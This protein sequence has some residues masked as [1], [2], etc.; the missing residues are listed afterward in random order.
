MFKTARAVAANTDLE[1]AQSF[2]FQQDLTF[3]GLVIAASGDDCFTK[4]RQVALELGDN[5]L[6]EGEIPDRLERAMTFLK[7]S[8][9]E[10]EESQI[11]L[12]SWQDNSKLTVLY[13]RNSGSNQAFLDRRGKLTPLTT[14][15]SQLIS[16]YIQPGDKILLINS[17]LSDQ[18]ELI[19]VEPDNLEEELNQRVMVSPQSPPLAAVLVSF[20]ERENLESHPGASETSDRIL[21][22]DSL[23]S[24]Q[25]DIFE[26]L[27]NYLPRDRRIIM[28]GGIIGLILLG[29][30]FFKFKHHTT[31]MVNTPSPSPSASVSN[32]YPAS[33]SLFLDLNLIKSGFSSQKLS[34]SLGNILLLDPKVGTLV[35][36]NLNK[37]SNQILGGKDQLGNVSAFSLNGDVA[38]TYSP[39][40]GVVKI[41][42]KA[43]KTQVVVKS[44]SDWGEI[45][46]L[47]AFGGNIYLLDNIKNQIWKYIPTDSGY[48][49]KLAY[50]RSGVS[51]DLSTSQRLEI[52]SS[53]WI[54]KSGFG[55]EKYTQGSP[56]SFS[57]GGLD[58]NI[59][60]ISNFFVSDEADNIY[61]IDSPN[62]RLLVLKKDGEYVAQYTS[63]QF[64][65]VSDMIVDEPNKR[66]YL[67]IGNGI[68]TLDLH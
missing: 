67:L 50:L 68:Y 61:I 15:N 26:K 24:L 31:P 39:E 6:T 36:L 30:L 46:D 28:V 43:E 2:V 60:D 35:E 40:K 16:G 59:K 57:P 55:L 48:S 27:K 22:L 34:Y 7:D 3:L 20:E 47:V 66:V 13:L 49:D 8:L 10:L 38:F 23:A 52:D 51:V 64:K 19:K 29:L 25:N 1:T 4:V 56:D 18:T 11:L 62:N 65:E 58:K 44:D 63:D 14:D 17:Y 32:V 9:K 21:N 37:K 41:D 33:L 12:S 42:T 54:L 45:K 53:V 5:F